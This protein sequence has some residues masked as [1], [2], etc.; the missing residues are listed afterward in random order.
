MG[1]IEA[2]KEIGARNLQNSQNG[3]RKISDIR[4]EWKHAST[5]ASNTS[6]YVWSLE[7]VCKICAADAACRHLARCDMSLA[8]YYVLYMYMQEAAL[9]SSQ[10]N[11]CRWDVKAEIERVEFS[12]TR[13][14]NSDINTLSIHTHLFILHLIHHPSHLLS[15]SCPYSFPCSAF[16]VLPQLS[17][18]TSV[19][20]R[21]TF[22]VTF[23]E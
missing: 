11:A 2:C 8:I 3:P 9:L 12:S 5:T 1:N 10:N 18:S 23:F 14:F 19:K 6:I 7:A 22:R 13:V 17:S 4:R 21:I 20:F 15:S 16:I